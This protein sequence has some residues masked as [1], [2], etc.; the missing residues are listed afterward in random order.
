MRFNPSQFCRA[1][2]SA[3][4]LLVILGM[5]NPVSAGTPNLTQLGQV[6]PTPNAS[7]P[8]HNTPT[9]HPSEPPHVTPTP[10]ASEPPHGTPTPHPSEPPHVTPTP[11]ASEPPHGTPTPHPSEPPHG[12]PTPNASEPPHAT[13]SPSVAV[14]PVNISTRLHIDTGEN[15]AIGGFMITGNTPKRVAIRGLGPSLQ[16]SGFFNTTLADPT[17]ELRGPNNSLIA[18]NDN[19]R[20]NLVWASELETV[21]LAPAFGSE[22]A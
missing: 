18:S 11:N 12:S 21:G 2:F 13:P 9:P 19:W 6:T 7:E 3:L 4:V 1:V 17:L 15:V 14:Q 22:S 5:S 8:P 20:D 16:A 10:N